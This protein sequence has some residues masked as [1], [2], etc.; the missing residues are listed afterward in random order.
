MFHRG[1]PHPTH[2]DDGRLEVAQEGV[3]ST[4]ASYLDHTGPFPGP[5][6]GPLKP[7]R[8]GQGVGGGHSSAASP[9][10]AYGT[11]E[12]VNR[13]LVGRAETWNPVQASSMSKL[14]AVPR[15]LDLRGWMRENGPTGENG[16][17]WSLPWA[18]C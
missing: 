13:F 9:K 17:S 10:L 4:E 5:A 14:R 11:W 7:R 18:W 8:G 1:I 2:P 12:A 16:T 3:L 6:G 15:K